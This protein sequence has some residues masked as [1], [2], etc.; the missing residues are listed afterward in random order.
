MKKHLLFC[1]SALLFIT[2]CKKVDERNRSVWE[3]RYSG[4]T[5]VDVFLNNKQPLP[6]TFTIDP[7]TTT[8]IATTRGILIK[9]P[10]GSFRRPNGTIVYTGDVKMTI[11]EYFSNTDLLTGNGISTMTRDGQMLITSGA[12]KVTALYNGSENLS[13]A[14]PINVSMPADANGTNADNRLF[15]GLDQST[16]ESLED[17]N[18]IVWIPDSVKWLNGQGT[19]NGSYD[20]QINDLNWWNLDRYASLGQGVTKLNVM[21]P[22]GFGNVNTMVAILLPQNGIT[23]MWGDNALQMFTLGHYNIPIGMPIKLLTI[24]EIGGQFKYDLRSMTVIP[25]ETVN[26]SSLQ[27]ITPS[28]LTTVIQNNLN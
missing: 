1:L 10:P 22:A 8:N 5:S 7:T 6:Q 9:V 2:S 28:S 19:P 12:F 23:R 26:I 4:L 17:N 13:L 27:D 11:M 24:A 3:N 20:F 15:T 18:H 21:L 16:A 14:Q 25:N